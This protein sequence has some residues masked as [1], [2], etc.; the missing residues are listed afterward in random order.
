[1]NVVNTLCCIFPPPHKHEYNIIVFCTITFSYNSSLPLLTIVVSVVGE[2]NPSIPPRTGTLPNPSND[3]KLVARIALKHATT[4]TIHNVLTE[5]PPLDLPDLESC[6]ERDPP[7]FNPC[8]SSAVR[9]AIS[10]FKSRFVCSSVLLRISRSAVKL[11]EKATSSSYLRR[12]DATSSVNCSGLILSALFRLSTPS[13]KDAGRL[14]LFELAVAAP[15]PAA[16]PAEVAPVSTTCLTCNFLL[17]TGKLL[18]LLALFHMAV[19]SST[20]SFLYCPPPPPPPCPSPMV[21][22]GSFAN[23]AENSSDTAQD[24]TRNLSFE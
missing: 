9:V 19:N 13:W 14:L 5:T 3:P 20:N 7:T 17:Y 12:R 8:F 11:T 21:I 22:L 23:L 18:L 24:C 16:P 15:P 10:R 6:D 1:M 4:T 2:S